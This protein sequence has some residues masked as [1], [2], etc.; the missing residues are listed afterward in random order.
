MVLLKATPNARVA[1]QSSGMH[2]KTSLQKFDGDIHF[3][4]INFDK[5]FDTNKAYVQSKL[6]N[7]LFPY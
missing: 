4:D 7:L 2:K 5:D 6:A 3:D 1:I